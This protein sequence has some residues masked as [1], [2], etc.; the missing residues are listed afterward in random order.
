MAQRS[1][2]AL[3][4]AAL[5]NPEIAPFAMFNIPLTSGKG[6]LWSIRSN[7]DTAEDQRREDNRS[8]AVAHEQRVQVMANRVGIGLT[9]FACDTH[10]DEVDD[11]PEDEWAHF[12]CGP[13]PTQRGW[14]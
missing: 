7:E 12:W 1:T 5:E 11:T 10:T 2:D 14:V 3:L 8:A 13:S 6:D 9:T 4:D